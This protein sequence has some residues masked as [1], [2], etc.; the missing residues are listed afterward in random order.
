M[1]TPVEE[2]RLHGLMAEFETSDQLVEACRRSYE[3]GYREQDAYSP[4]PIHALSEVLHQGRSKVPLI[5][6]IGGILGAC[7]GF[8]LQYV[9]AVHVYPLNIGGRPL[10]SWPAFIP[11]T[12]EVTILL[13]GIFGV[14]GMILLNGLPRPHH[15]VFN[16]DRFAAASLDGFFLCI[17]ATDPKFDPEETEAFLRSL[18]PSEVSEVEN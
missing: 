8:L 6:L 14:V 9:T 15:P 1:H 7:T 10:N 13:A 5:M 4:Y 17:E 16:V 11:I 3:A 18:G 2:P 12:F